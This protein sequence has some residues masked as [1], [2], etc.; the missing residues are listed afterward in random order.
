MSKTIEER[1]KAI[2]DKLGIKE[3]TKHKNYDRIY[4]IA[5]D[6]SELVIWKTTEEG[7]NFWVDVYNKLR[8]IADKGK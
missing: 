2:E 1:L 7:Q 8:R 4:K 3:D 5:S 6:L